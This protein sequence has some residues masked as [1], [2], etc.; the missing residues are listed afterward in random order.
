M[1]YK[2]AVRVP[3]ELFKRDLDQEKQFGITDLKLYG[4]WE[5]NDSLTIVGQAFA[6]RLKNACCF[7]CSVYCF[8]GCF[9]E[10]RYRWDKRNFWISDANSFI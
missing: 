3:D 8:F 1:A 2:K 5:N 10:K 7:I 4:Y 6:P 9:Y